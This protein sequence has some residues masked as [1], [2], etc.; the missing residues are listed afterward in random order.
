MVAARGRSFQEFGRQRKLWLA[1][2]GVLLSKPAPLG[3]FWWLGWPLPPPG[4]NSGRSPES[5]L[6]KSSASPTLVH[7]RPSENS[8][9]S[10]RRSL[11]SPLPWTPPNMWPR[12]SVIACLARTSSV[13]STPLLN[14]RAPERN[15][16]TSWSP[17]STASMAIELGTSFSG[18]WRRRH[19]ISRSSWSS[20]SPPQ[21]AIAHIWQECPTNRRK[22]AAESRRPFDAHTV[23]RMG[24][25]TGTGPANAALQ[26]CERMIAWRIRTSAD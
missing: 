14:T 21:P 5:P 17:A 25:A 4:I 20:S 6:S 2:L 8:I 3:Y 12:P 23:S 24:S 15:T 16:T 1:N 19:A 13:K 7:R 22:S 9:P 18:R 10:S 11:G 26:P